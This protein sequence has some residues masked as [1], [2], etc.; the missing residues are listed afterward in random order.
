MSSG[1]EEDEEEL[2]WL[3]LLDEE[4][5]ESGVESGVIGSR[6]TRRSSKEQASKEEIRGKRGIRREESVGEGR[7]ERERVGRAGWE[8][9]TLWP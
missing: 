3:E 2:L 6:P 1:V 8:T 7:V 4:Q 9:W 5:W